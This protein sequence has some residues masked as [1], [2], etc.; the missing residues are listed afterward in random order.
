M[1][2][3]PSAKTLDINVNLISILSISY[4]RETFHLKCETLKYFKYKYE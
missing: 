2:Q 3:E 4:F 1:S